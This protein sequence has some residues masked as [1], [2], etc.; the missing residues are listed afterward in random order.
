[1]VR[2]VEEARRSAESVFKITGNPM[3][4]CP[5]V[6]G[7]HD[8]EWIE[9]TVNPHDHVDLDLETAEALQ[10]TTH[11]DAKA[12]AMQRIRI[13]RNDMLRY[14]YSD[15]C[16]KCMDVKGGNLLSTRLHTDACRFRF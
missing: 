5:N 9:E 6:D 1:M 8:A 14:G 2:L 16:P 15:G 13:T 10:S 7:Q 4:P 3:P 12:R 11:A